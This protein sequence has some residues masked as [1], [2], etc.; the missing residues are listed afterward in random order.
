MSNQERQSRYKIIPITVDDEKNLTIRYD[1]FDSI[2]GHIFVA[3]A[4][5]GLCYLG[6]GDEPDA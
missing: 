1:S 5:K 6:I 4:D 2:Y 3:E